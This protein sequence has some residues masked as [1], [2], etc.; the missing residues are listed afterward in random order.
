MNKS[1]DSVKYLTLNPLKK[2]LINRFLGNIDF[3]IKKFHPKTI[4]DVGCGEGFVDQFLIKKNP[5]YRISGIDISPESIRLAKKRVPELLARQGNVYN[6]SFKD[7]SFDLVICMEVLEHL[8]KPQKAIKEIRRV[9]KKYC[10]FSVPNEPIFSFLSLLSGSYIK[11]L[12]RHPDHIN[13][14]SKK[15]FQ[16]LIQRYFNKIIMYTYIAWIIAIGEK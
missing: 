5:Q 14:W 11:R 6:L 9:S 3:Y 7:N 15:S 13:Y 10:L 8:D 4:L 16:N 12:G 1:Q 2:I